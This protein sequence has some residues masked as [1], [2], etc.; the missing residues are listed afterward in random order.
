VTRSG[1]GKSD[2]RIAFRPQRYRILSKNGSC[3]RHHDLMCVR[4][5]ASVALTQFVLCSVL[6]C[7]TARRQQATSNTI[8]SVPPLEFNDST[9]LDIFLRGLDDASIEE[10][11]ALTLL[12]PAGQPSRQGIATKGHLRW[13]DVAPM[14]YTIEVVVPGLERKVQEVDV[15]EAG[16]VRIIIQVPP[17]TG[18]DRVYPPVSSDADVNHIFGAYASKLGDWER[19]KSYWAKVLEQDP[20][21]VAAMVSVGEV[22]LSQ[23][24]TS[25]ALP[26]LERAARTDPSVSLLLAR[27]LVTAA[28]EVLQAYLKDHPGDVAAKKQLENLKAPVERRAGENLNADSG[29]RIASMPPGRMASALRESGW[30]PPNIDD[31]V[32]P[33]E[34]GS[35]CNLEEVVQKAGEK[36]QE[37]V[38]NVER[39]TATESFL[40]ESINK[41]GQVSVTEK[42]KYDYMVSIQ[43]IRPGI[44]G[45]EEYLSRGTT[46]VEFPG[47]ITTK[48]LPALILIFHPYYSESFS[49]KC[50]GLAM[51]NGQRAWQIYFRQREDKPN[52]IRA[53]RFGRNARP[54]ALKG[55]AWIVADSYQ[56]VDLQTDLVDALPDIRLTVDHT[57]IEYGPVHFSSR[58]VDMWLPQTA[59]VFSELRGKR[60]HRRLGFSNYLFFAVDD[61]QKIS[62]PATSP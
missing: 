34:S 26:Y 33:I 20:D 35:A 12:T 45:V 6:V 9:G 40:H 58:G 50:E 56:I 19:A 7:G 29:R 55:R 17:Q 32:P 25:E 44:L 52:G 49:M 57:S 18:Q 48:G 16:E 41:S 62:S 54:I 31:N 53:Y 1:A 2:N 22:L 46:P 36:I 8:P 5:P 37:F 11:A 15:P 47:G 13:S 4:I 59:E 60:I 10:T 42:R 38:K 24:K 51:V 14:H 30:L 28:T 61:T 39:F 23:N 3:R 43:E 21:N 27:A